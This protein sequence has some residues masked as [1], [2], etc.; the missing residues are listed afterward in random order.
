M[1]V[2]V[3]DGTLILE[4][5]S[6]REDFATKAPPNTALTATVSGL[7]AGVYPGKLV[8]RLHP[9]EREEEISDWSVTVEAAP[10]SIPV[11]SFYN[12]ETGHYFITASNAERDGIFN[13]AA[14]NA[15]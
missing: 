3:E 6:Y 5:I 4:Y 14:G 12:R 15:S 9:D 10:D 11:H 13:G 1:T 8:R 2:H 7:P